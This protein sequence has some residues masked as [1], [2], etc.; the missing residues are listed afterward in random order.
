VELEIKE[1]ARDGRGIGRVKGLVIF[2]SGA[3]VGEKVKVRLARVAA[4]HAHA[5]VIERY[6]IEAKK[7]N[8]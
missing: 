7:A 1:K 5:E 4:R 3:S 8:P 2:V 6:Q